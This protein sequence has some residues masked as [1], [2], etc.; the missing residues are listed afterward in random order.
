MNSTYQQL[1]KN[2]EYLNLKQMIEHL[3]D[4]I[5]FSMNNQLSFV[6]TLVKLT[7]YEIDVREKSMINSMVKVAGF[8]HR[9]EL[10]EFDFE[11][12]PTIN[13]QQMLDFT[14]LRF[15]EEKENIVF[16]GTSGVGKTHLATSI[17]I[18]AAKKRTSTYFIK[19][20]DLIMNLKR[21]KLENRLESRLKHY[22]KYKLLIIDEIGYLPIDREDAKLFFQLIDLRYEKKST[23][24]TTNI[25]FKE[26]DGVFQDTMLANAILD[27]VLHHATVVNIV[28]DSYRIK[29]HFEIEND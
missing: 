16:L 26:W 11:F 5:D 1:L 3:S 17:G 2:L 23:I 9:K 13:K 18:A 8:P 15:L 28:G 12:Q 21:A 7:N 10:S 20:N 6:D 24:L 27:R 25:S 14:S 29:N 4:T 22:T 19:C